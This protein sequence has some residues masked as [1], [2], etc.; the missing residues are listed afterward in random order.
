M[1]PKHDDREPQG[2]PIREALVDLGVKPQ[3][4][5]PA[6]GLNLRRKRLA[7]ME[8]EGEETPPQKEPTEEPLVD[9]NVKPRQ[10]GAPS[11][12]LNLRRRRLSDTVPEGEEVPPQPPTGQQHQRSLAPGEAHSEGPS[13]ESESSAEPRRPRLVNIVAAPEAT[14][15]EGTKPEA[16]TLEGQEP[17]PKVGRARATIT[18]SPEDPTGLQSIL[19][20]PRSLSAV[21]AAG[22]GE[23]EVTVSDRP[24]EPGLS[25]ALVGGV[26]A[27]LAA[28]L[29][30]A[31]ITMATGY[32]AGWM[33]VGMGLLIGGAVRTT[34]RGKG[35]SF[36]Y[37]SAAVWILGCLLGN[38][39]SVCAF[40]AGQESLSP[41]YVLTY[42][43]SEPAR[44]PGAMLATFQFL[45]LLFWGVGLYVA[46][47]LSFRRIAHAETA[48][49]DSGK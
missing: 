1:G 47:R 33:A 14:T 23:F 38:F 15:P 21:L 22:Q 41:I 29:V 32:H 8:P 30:W 18:Q 4:G 42:I 19:D 2:E 17:R 49:S 46:Y 10:P 48:D 27:A 7:E 12:G 5:A 43:C 13:P 40:V 45:D 35:K 31:L 34:A 36:G 37:L 6:T 24:A 26:T 25:A 3:P 44:I 28:A 9:L 11:A 39:L 20:P 16:T